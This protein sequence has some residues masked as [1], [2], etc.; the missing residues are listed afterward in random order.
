[1]FLF[2]AYSPLSA[3]ANKAGGAKSGVVG[4]ATDGN[5]AETAEET[6]EIP[7]LHGLSMC[8]FTAFAQHACLLVCLS[9]KVCGA[10]SGAAGEG[11]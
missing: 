11:E 3:R 5:A 10:K 8:C 2:V 1:M 6:G 4:N 9:A 7:S